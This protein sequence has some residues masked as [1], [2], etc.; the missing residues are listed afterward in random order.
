MSGT[1]F[2]FQSNRAGPETTLGSR[3]TGLTRGTSPFLSAP[4]P[5]HLVQQ[6]TP[7]SL[8]DSPH[9]L[10]TTDQRAP[11]SSKERALPGTV[12]RPKSLTTGS[13]DKKKLGHTSI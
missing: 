8:E 7:R 4:A 9:D 2:L 10:R 11:R 1:Q 3:K 6:T 5:G 13:Q 12:T